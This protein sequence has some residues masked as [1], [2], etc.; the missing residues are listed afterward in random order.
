VHELLDDR[1]APRTERMAAEPAT[2]SLDAGD[3]NALQLAGVAVEGS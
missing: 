3:A 1:L 2:K